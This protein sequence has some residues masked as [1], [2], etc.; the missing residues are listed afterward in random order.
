MI[1]SVRDRDE[2][3]FLA[4]HDQRVNDEGNLGSAKQAVC[5]SLYS[6]LFHFSYFVYL[7]FINHAIYK[8]VPTMIKDQILSRNRHLLTASY[9]L[10]LLG[11]SLGTKPTRSLVPMPPTTQPSVQLWCPYSAETPLPMPDRSAACLPGSSPP[12]AHH[13]RT[14]R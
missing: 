12:H 14:F 9:P 10:K 4:A 7:S 1:K 6:Y 11:S 5:H 3:P 2:R 13:R 8:Y